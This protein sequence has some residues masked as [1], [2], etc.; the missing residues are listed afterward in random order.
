MF[1]N[2]EFF[3]NINNSQNKVSIEVKPPKGIS[4]ILFGIVSIISSVIAFGIMFGSYC[5][6]NFATEVAKR[7]FNNLKFM[8]YTAIAVFSLSAVIFGI[9]AIKSFCKKEKSST[10]VT[11]SLIIS[12]LGLILGTVTVIMSFVFFFIQ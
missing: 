12:I 5:A 4:N 11:I 10:S 8:I 6:L 2:N 1:E 3:T 7:P 9:I